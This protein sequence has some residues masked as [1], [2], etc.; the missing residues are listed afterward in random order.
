[1]PENKDKD[2]NDIYKLVSSILDNNKELNMRITEHS[3]RN[4]SSL[5][6]LNSKFDFFKSDVLEEISNLKISQIEKISEVKLNSLKDISGINSRIATIAAP[7]GI[8][9]TLISFFWDYIKTHK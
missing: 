7:F 4:E 1:M 5:S 9:P 3:R 6:N 2:I 8:L